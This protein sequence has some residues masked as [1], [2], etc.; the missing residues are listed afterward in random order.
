MLGAAL[1]LGDTLG[2]ADEAGA[3]PG[4]TLG[5][6]EE[7]GAPG[8]GETLGD[9]AEAGDGEADGFKPVQGSP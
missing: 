8:L 1:G 7:V 4:E 2:D 9:A 5:D 3:A 6:I